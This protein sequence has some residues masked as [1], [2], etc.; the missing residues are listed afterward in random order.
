MYNPQQ[1]I[2]RNSNMANKV[3]SASGLKMHAL[4]L[5]LAVSIGAHAMD[6][7]EITA[8]ID[9][10]EHQQALD[11]IIQQEQ[12]GVEDASLK[13]LKGAVLVRL[14]RLDEAMMEFLEL[15]EDHP[16]DAAI[17]N[18]IGVIHAERGRFV[19]A[20][21]AFELALEL[22]PDYTQALYNLGDVYAELACRTFGKVAGS[23]AA[24]VP[25]Y[26]EPVEKV[27]EAG[28]S[29]KS[30]ASTTTPDNS[31]EIIQVVHG[32]RN[33]W[34]GQN[35][36]NYLSYYSELFSPPGMPRT[37]WEKKRRSSLQRPQWIKIEISDQQVEIVDGQAT[38]R[39]KQTYNSNTY[40]D[41]V[42]KLLY[43]RKESDGWKI[44]KESI[45]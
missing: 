25:G 10:G 35:V 41:V 7:D 32:W 45:I 27:V 13:L 36:E 42:T 24:D 2:F 11:A 43:L 44:V 40:K 28:V 34:A 37:Y 38:V 16:A 18:N 22:S 14:G 33:A 9:R 3:F 8:F 1:M 23:E 20:R 21:N 15:A 29:S 19:K 30:A 5:L 6:G 31:E 39:F 4:W 12:S 17:H 26:C